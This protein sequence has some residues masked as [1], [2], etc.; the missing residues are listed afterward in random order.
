MQ[1]N[2]TKS[3]SAEN[4]NSMIWVGSVLVLIFI[5]SSTTETNIIIITYNIKDFW[6]KFNEKPGSVTSEGAEPG[7][8]DLQKLE[9]IA[10]VINQEKSDMIAVLEYASLAEFLFFNE[11]FLEDN[12]TC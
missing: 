3:R 6:L 10:A 7:H 4:E 5:C 2:S 9:I 12:Y 1:C 11:R 8:D